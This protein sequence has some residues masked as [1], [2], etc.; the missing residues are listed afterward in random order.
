M[1]DAAY[2]GSGGGIMMVGC[3]W[4]VEGGRHWPW[5]VRCVR[6]DICIIFVCCHVVNFSVARDYFLLALE[7]IFYLGPVGWGRLGL[8]RMEYVLLCCM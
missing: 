3:C 5:T 6:F 1:T 4:M 2:Y 8:C 7:I